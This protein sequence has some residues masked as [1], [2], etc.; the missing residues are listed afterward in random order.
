MKYHFGLLISVLLILFQA[1]CSFIAG[2][3]RSRGNPSDRL[4]LTGS[5]T[6]A[7][8]AAEIA[9]RFEAQ[10]PEVRIDVQTGGSGKGIADV[11]LAVADIGMASRPLAPDEADLTA[12][13]IAADGVGLIL[14]ES[15]PLHELSD[16]QIVAIYTD[17]I[18]N[19]QDVGGQDQPITVVHKAEGRA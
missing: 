13:Q 1:G 12:H 11:R 7:P 6:V 15:N 9:L 2:R 18:N 14:H 4:T 5:S 3:E 19:W 17:K 8:L 10:H 16:Q